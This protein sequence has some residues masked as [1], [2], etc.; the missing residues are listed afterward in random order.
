MK[1]N[2]FFRKLLCSFIALIMILQ[3]FSGCSNENLT[4][5]T[6]SAG[7]N[8][9]NMPEDTE[10]N[11]HMPEF[12]PNFFEV[13][14]D[15]C[16]VYAHD[17]FAIINGAQFSMISAQPLTEEDVKVT[18]SYDGTVVTALIDESRGVD[19]R[20]WFDEYI[21]F[22]F[23][24]YPAED[25]FKFEEGRMAGSQQEEMNDL[26]L[27]FQELALED[28][29]SLYLYTLYFLPQEFEY[30]VKDM[31]V[32]VHDVSKTYEFEQM[33]MLDGM[34]T[35]VEFYPAE[36]HPLRVENFITEGA[37]CGESEDGSFEIYTELVISEDVSL[38]NIWIYGTPEAEVLGAEVIQTDA[39]GNEM[40]SLWDMESDFPLSAG[41]SVGVVA[42]VRDQRTAGL[43]WQ[44][45]T[46]Y[47]IFDYTVDGEA[48]YSATNSVF[49]WQRQGNPYIY[50]AAL[51][52]Y[53]AFR[54]VLY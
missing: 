16:T 26:R 33:V 41:E 34:E 21:F 51:Q 14:C 37:N 43:L 52:G 46:L 20:E 12:E 49:I 32:T 27:A 45:R 35:P 2:V 6:L 54:F 10:I 28:I 9:A 1:R 39:E 19:L 15:N 53:D 40:S 13:F 47:L 25:I 18:T 22:L 24:G 11:Y 29:P 38:R 36:Q 17:G 50:L 4:D 7:D 30:D 44:N 31:T 3:C 8:L 48:V 42:Y 5:Y 23:Q